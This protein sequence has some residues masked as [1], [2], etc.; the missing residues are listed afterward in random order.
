MFLT[1]IAG[2]LAG[3]ADGADAID[4]GDVGLR[5]KDTDKVVKKD[6]TKSKSKVGTEDNPIIVGEVANKKMIKKA[7]REYSKY[8]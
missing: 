3:T 2:I 6:T 5:V 1:A 4:P 8:Q 7:L